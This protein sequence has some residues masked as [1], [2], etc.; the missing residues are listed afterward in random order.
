MSANNDPQSIEVSEVFEGIA[1]MLLAPVVLPLASAVNQPLVQSALKEGIAFAERCQEAVADAQERLEDTF[2]AVQA[3][4]DAERRQTDEAAGEDNGILMRSDRPSYQRT[5]GSYGQEST[6]T[7]SQ[8]RDT[9]TELNQQIRWLT[10]DLLDL[11]LLVSIGLASFA[12]RQIL[13]RGVRLDEIPWYA[14]AWYALDTF[15]KF[16][17]DTDQPNPS[18][19]EAS[20]VPRTIEVESDE[21]P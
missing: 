13:V 5:K 16:H 20:V 7:A 17:P 8:V 14:L 6:Q 11:R 2:A 9:V 18:P 15:V 1:A 4:V 19:A 12:L 21:T 3:E 10:N